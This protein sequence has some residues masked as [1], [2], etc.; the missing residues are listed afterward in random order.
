[1][2]MDD[3]MKTNTTSND[4]RIKVTLNPSFC[5]RTFKD[6][7]RSSDKGH[8]ETL[9]AYVNPNYRIRKDQVSNVFTGESNPKPDSHLKSRY[10]ESKVM[11]NDSYVENNPQ[12]N[13]GKLVRYLYEKQ[14]K[15]TN[16]LY[17]DE[18]LMY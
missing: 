18:L 13:R 7:L 6:A 14:L 1:M 17:S 2:M 11:F 8:P 10:L 12:I 9:L 3:Q 4:F 15:D 5:D 16:H